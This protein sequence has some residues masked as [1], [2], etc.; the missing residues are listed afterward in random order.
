[1]K[2]FKN[3]SQSVPGPGRPL[4]TEKRDAVLRAAMKLFMEHGLAGVTLDEIASSAKVTKP[5]IYNH[6]GSKHELFSIC[7]RK[8]CEGLTGSDVFAR[9][10]GSSP[11]ADL[12]AIGCAFMDLIYSPDA[13]ALHRIMVLESEKH[14]EMSRLFYEAGPAR[15]IERL[16]GY[17]GVLE[18]SHQLRFDDR[19]GA[20]RQFLALFTGEMQLR[21]LFRIPP[22]PTK[23]EFEDFARGN[24]ALFLRAHQVPKEL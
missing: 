8:K 7:I 13:L 1:M 16:A 3:S 12:Y 11:E 17:L 24:V 23:R 10:S 14:E 19:S 18:D 5:T 15:L 22:L 9:L 20:A 21:V 4:D 6:F 2:K